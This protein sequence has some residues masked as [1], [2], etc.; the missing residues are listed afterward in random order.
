MEAARGIQARDGGGF[1]RRDFCRR[2]GFPIRDTADFQSAL[3]ENF[4]E[5]TV[6]HF[7]FTNRKKTPN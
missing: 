6:R 1:E 4:I 2:G 5:T 3:P 7:N